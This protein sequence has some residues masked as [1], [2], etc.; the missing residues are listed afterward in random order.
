MNPLASVLGDG[1][2]ILLQLREGFNMGLVTEKKRTK[3]D[4]D[5]FDRL[6]ASLPKTE[7]CGTKEGKQKFLG[8]EGKKGKRNKGRGK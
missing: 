1:L 5:A 8:G 2:G 6:L 7:P 3:E 4:Q